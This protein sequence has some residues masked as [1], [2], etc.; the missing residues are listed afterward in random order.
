MR[1]SFSIWWFA[2]VL[3]LAYGVVIIEHWHLGTQ[4]PAAQSARC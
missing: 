4:S 1:E 2:G 3:L